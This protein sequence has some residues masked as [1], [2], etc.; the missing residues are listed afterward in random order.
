MLGQY[1]PTMTQILLF[2]LWFES[3]TYSQMDRISFIEIKEKSQESVRLE[4]LGSFVS[5]LTKKPE[6][7]QRK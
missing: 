1:P 2:A 4:R 7:K 5:E 6:H 3:V